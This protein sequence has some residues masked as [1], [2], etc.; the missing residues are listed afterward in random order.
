ML[1]SKV[2]LNPADMLSLF[3]LIPIMLQILKT[4]TLN[5]VVALISTTISLV[6]VPANKTVL[7]S[8]V[9][10]VNMLFWLNLLSLV[11][12]SQIYQKRLASLLVTSISVVTMFLLLAYL[13][14][15]QF[16]KRQ[17]ISM[18]NITLS[19]TLFPRKE[20]SWTM[21]TQ[22]SILQISSQSALILTLSLLLCP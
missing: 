14:T 10:K 19:E 13:L 8:L 17:N 9:Q 6:G 22:N 11:F 21:L 18:S 2:I 3:Y 20:S 12:T 15:K 4:E 16:I 1:K 5:V 7:L